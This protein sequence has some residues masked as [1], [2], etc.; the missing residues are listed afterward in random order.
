MPGSP[1]ELQ[2]FTPV[3]KD[4]YL[5]IR[6]KAF[7]LMTPLLANARRFGKKE[8]QYGGNDLFFTVKLGRRGGFVA[9]ARG[10]L[11]DGKIAVEKKGRLSI[12]RTYA[13]VSIDGLAIKATQGSKSS[14]I[15]AAKKVVEDVMEEWQ[16]EQ[17]RILYSDSL[18]IRAIIDTVTDTTHVICSSPYGITSSGPGNLHLVVDDVIAVLITTGATL[19][20]KTT[21]SAISL[22]GD[23]ATLTY[24]AAVAGQVATDI[25]VSC[26]TAATDTNDTSFGAEPHGIKSILD[27]EAAFGTF[28]GIK[29]DRWV[30]QKLTSSTVDETIVMR[31]LNTIR[32]RAGVDWRTDPKQLLLMTTTGI[33]QAYGE[34][35]LGLRR[36]DAPTMQLKGGFTG[37]A[38]GGAALVDDPWAPRGRINAIHGPS[39]VFIDLM[40]FGEI[41]F[42]DAPRWRQS[43]T[44]DAWEANFASYWNFG[45]YLRNA[46]GVISGIT[47]TVNYSP[48][49]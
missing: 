37:V 9:S 36:F 38:V 15:P 3:L 41:S 23:N 33:W 8:V 18:A 44:R 39:T 32:N 31:L 43:N 27:V 28:E 35:L 25:I 7:P 45:A 17:N 26:V 49:S 21:I 46:H 42:Q 4:V 11:P 6:K 5:P 14:Y 29:D 10:F 24:S 34:S 2:D 40:D 22:S 13:T 47:D 12:A 48:V 19:R 1:Q 16:L 20:G 30:A